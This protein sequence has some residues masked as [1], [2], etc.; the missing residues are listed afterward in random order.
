MCGR[1]STLQNNSLAG[2]SIKGL[3]VIQQHGVDVSPELD[4]EES[5]L[6]TLLE[7]LAQTAVLLGEFLGDVSNINRLGMEEV[8]DAYKINGKRNDKT[9][10]RVHV[11]MKEWVYCIGLNGHQAQNE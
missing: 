1:H 3:G 2:D 9:H 10:A 4:Q 5:V 8:I 11:H 7:Q 6:R